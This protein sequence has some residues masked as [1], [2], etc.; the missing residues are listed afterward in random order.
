MEIAGNIYEGAVELPYKN[1]IE[2]I[3]D[4]MFTSGKREK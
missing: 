4:L 2:N 1:L 3:I